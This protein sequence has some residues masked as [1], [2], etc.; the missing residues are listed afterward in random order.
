VPCSRAENARGQ[1]KYCSQQLKDAGDSDPDKAERQEDY[2]HNGI[3]HERDKR[4]RPR[5]NEKQTP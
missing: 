4:Y 2:P 5:D 1:R 3:K